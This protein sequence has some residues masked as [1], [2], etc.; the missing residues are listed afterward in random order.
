MVYTDDVSN[1]SQLRGIYLDLY[2]F[3]AIYN[4]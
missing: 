1:Y 2:Q 4:K 3:G